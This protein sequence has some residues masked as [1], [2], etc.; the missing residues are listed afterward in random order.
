[1]HNLSCLLTFTIHVL[2]TFQT[3]VLVIVG[4]GFGF[5]IIFHIGTPD[6]SGKQSRRK[7]SEIEICDRTE[8]SETEVMQW[9]DW[10]QEIQFY[11]V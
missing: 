9:R 8:T 10:L 3:L 1:M 4:I 2:M 7:H 5:Q 11:Q 6:K